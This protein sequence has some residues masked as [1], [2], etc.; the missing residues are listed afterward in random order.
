MAF[1]KKRGMS[2]DY[3]EQGFV[4]FTCANYRHLPTKERRKIDALIVDVGGFDCEALRSLMLD[5]R[6]SVL[7]VSM[8]YCISEASLNRLRQKFYDR[9]YAELTK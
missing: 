6:Q 7:S 8:E 1:K 5:V 3:N 2:L 4:Y 9:A